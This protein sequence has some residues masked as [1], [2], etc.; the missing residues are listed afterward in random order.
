MHVLI[1]TL[2]MSS[3][4]KSV[5]PSHDRLQQ[6]QFL[7]FCKTPGLVVLAMDSQKTVLALSILY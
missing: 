4:V 6:E 5:E 2:S 1:Y 7:I 3:L